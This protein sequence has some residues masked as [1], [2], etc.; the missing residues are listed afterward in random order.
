M[1]QLKF[2][3]ILSAISALGVVAN[4]LLELPAD[5]AKG[6]IDIGKADGS[7]AAIAYAKSLPQNAPEQMEARKAAAAARAADAE[8][9][10]ADADAKAQAEAQAA[11]DAEAAEQA[12]GASES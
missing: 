4:D 9:A 6:L 1:A 10:Q 2:V 11:A 8:A 5:E 7:K 12:A 3:R